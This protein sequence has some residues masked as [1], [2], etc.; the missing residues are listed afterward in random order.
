[1]LGSMLR[2]AY[3]YMYSNEEIHL[4][5]WCSLFQLHLTAIDRRG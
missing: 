3:L 1:V 2:T 5:D 4:R